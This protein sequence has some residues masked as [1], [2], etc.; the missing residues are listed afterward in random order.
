MLPA[1]VMHQI[2][3]RCDAGPSPHTAGGSS[4]L[5]K[6]SA[7]RYTTPCWSSIA[8]TQE[9]DTR[10]ATVQLPATPVNRRIVR[11][12]GRKRV[13]LSTRAPPAERFTS[14]TSR[15]GRSRKPPSQDSSARF[16]RMVRRRSGE[17]PCATAPSTTWSRVDTPVHECVR[18]P[19]A[20]APR[21]GGPFGCAE[22]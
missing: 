10:L 22:R 13:G 17:G 15:P 9:R 14:A 8:A 2:G 21:T 6:T 4:A 20:H 16:L 19:R 7:P 18:W 12:P 3:S 1:F 11:A 5:S